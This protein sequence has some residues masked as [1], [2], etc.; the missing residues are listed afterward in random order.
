MGSSALATDYSIYEG[1][2]TIDGNLSDW[3]DATWID[4]ATTLDG[5]GIDLSEAKFAV[6]WSSATNLIYVAVTGVDMNHVFI[7]PAANTGLWNVTD[8]VE[9]YVDPLELNKTN[10]CQKVDGDQSYWKYAQQYCGGLKTD[11]SVWCAIAGMDGYNDGTTTFNTNAIST[12]MVNFAAS[13]DGDTINYEIA[14]KP[15]KFFN[16]A[17]PSASSLTTLSGGQVIGFDVDMG[18]SDGWDYIFLAENAVKNKYLNAAGFATYTL[19]GTDTTKTDIEFVKVGD[20]GN[21]ADTLLVGSGYYGSV[22]YE[23]YIGKY[24]ITAAQYAKFLN[25]VASISDPHVLYNTRMADNA[26]VQR[27]I[28]TTN[29]DG[30]FTYTVKNGFANRPMG[31]VTWAMAARYCN[32]LT[33]GA[34]STSST[35]TGVYNFNTNGTWPYT[36]ANPQAG[37]DNA[38]RTGNTPA[39]WIPNCNEYY[40]AGYYNSSTQ[41]YY[42]Y[43]TSTDVAPTAGDYDSTNSGNWRQNNIPVLNAPFYYTEVGTFENTVSPYGCRDLLGNVIEYTEDILVHWSVN[44]Y[45]YSPRGHGG[46]WYSNSSDYSK[47]KFFLGY[48]IGKGNA[49]NNYAVSDPT[50]GDTGMRICCNQAAIDK[51]TRMPGDANGDKMVD[52]G[53]LGILAANYGGSGKTWAQGDFNGD[54]LVDVGDLGILAAH[55]GE[56]AVNPSSA[57]FNADY[58]KAF[59]TTVDSED[60]ADEVGSSVCSSLGLPLVAGLMLI[61]LMIVKLEE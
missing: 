59:G 53:D 14:I 61:G 58:A 23:F 28:K 51:N 48:P 17:N 24:E 55:Y 45:Y 30:T 57:D 5:I 39:Y 32:W 21:P 56:G 16:L 44:A 11:G 27:I 43:F 18:S 35:E 20:A 29:S 2:A 34:T 4:L 50:N 49:G 9:V 60:T 22:T 26:Y 40:K 41:T 1:T 8:T 38:L 19:V 6:R 54:T 37:I 25:S 46:G 36:I 42:D 3:S 12:G 52:V 31:C 13:V 47:R 10:Y 33:N 15:Y 7:D